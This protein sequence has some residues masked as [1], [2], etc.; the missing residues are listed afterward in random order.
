MLK[1]HERWV[2]TR[3][4]ADK[5]LMGQYVIQLGVEVHRAESLN[6]SPVFIRALADIAAKHLG[7]YGTGKAGPT[8]VQLG[9]RC[10]GCKNAT[11]GHQK[12]WFARRG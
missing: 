9:L 6:D 1:R 4:V 2:T 3:R 12:A 7:D 8:S 5:L 11:C 10:P